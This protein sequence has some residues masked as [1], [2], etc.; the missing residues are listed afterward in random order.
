MFLQYL[1][2][3]R[4]GINWA[5][6]ARSA[7]LP[8][9]MFSKH[10]NGHQEISPKNYGKIFRAIIAVTGSAIYDGKIWILEP[11]NPGIVL[12][13]DAENWDN[14]DRRGIMDAHDLSVYLSK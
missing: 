10:W 5:D 12:W 2:Q 14:Q 6:V 8:R 1:D 11:L 9:A 4:P 7:G 3:I 13:L